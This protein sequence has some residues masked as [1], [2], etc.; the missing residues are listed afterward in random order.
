MILIPPSLLCYSG[1]RSVLF[2]INPVA[3][4]K[5]RP[6]AQHLVLGVAENER[7]RSQ[8]RFI[9]HAMATNSIGRGRQSWNFPF[10]L[11]FLN[12]LCFFWFV[13][14]CGFEFSKLFISSF[15]AENLR[16]YLTYL[17][18]RVSEMLA[19]IEFCSKNISEA[20]NYETRSWVF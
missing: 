11:L 3:G 9:C 10:F 8:F 12:C 1:L 17:C 4:E 15:L 18:L 20:S 6:P 7:G 16:G 19:T 5:S 13:H 14:S 2:S